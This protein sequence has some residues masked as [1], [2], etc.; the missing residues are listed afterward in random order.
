MAR[1]LQHRHNNAYDTIL[2]VEDGRVIGE[3]MV[4]SQGDELANFANPG[5]LRDWEPTNP[6]VTDPEAY[7]EL[8]AKGVGD[9]PA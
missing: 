4:G 5:D 6:E 2:L 8:V 9:A 7:G 3:W 1:E